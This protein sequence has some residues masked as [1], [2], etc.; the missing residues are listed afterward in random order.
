MYTI[1]TTVN[2][3]LPALGLILLVLGVF[4]GKLVYIVLAL[5]LSLIGLL[6]QYE[7]AGGEILGSYFDYLNATI[8]TA[9]LCILLASLV[10]VALKAP[11]LHGKVTRYIT[12]A[13][14]ALTITG[15]VTLTINLWVNACFIEG[16]VPGS[17]VMQVVNFGSHPAYCSYQYLFYRIGAN[18]K[19]GYLCPGHYGLL[20]STGE[21]AIAP[22]FLM[23]QLTQHTKKNAP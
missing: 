12:G 20:P 8:Y 19:V 3:I 23:H 14:A 17:P 7:M 9:N 18:G 10:L 4:W 16:R 1:S 11:S 5:W 15:A 6:I 21:V 2:F 22:D 13:V